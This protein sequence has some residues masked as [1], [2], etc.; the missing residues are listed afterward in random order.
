VFLHNI[1]LWG[2]KADNRWSTLINPILG[3]DWVYRT[4]PNK[5]TVLKVHPLPNLGEG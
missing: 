1:Y 5:P 4:F 2:S 3:L